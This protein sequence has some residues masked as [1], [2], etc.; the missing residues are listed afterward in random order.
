[1]LLLF[2]N[3]W[4][5]HFHCKCFKKQQHSNTFVAF[6][7]SLLLCFL[8]IPE[9]LF[10]F[11][12][13]IKINKKQHFTFE[14]LLKVLKH[15]YNISRIKHTSYQ[16]IYIFFPLPFGKI[17][18]NPFLYFLQKFIIKSLSQWSNIKKTSLTTH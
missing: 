1:M 14:F 15:L 16:Y 8:L 17:E 5:T 6:S 13:L 7:Q 2:G 10:T 12:W 9:R 18:K 11:H 3:V 4:T